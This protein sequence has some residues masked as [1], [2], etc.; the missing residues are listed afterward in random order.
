MMTVDEEVQEHSYFAQHKQCKKYLHSQH[1][2]P[3]LLAKLTNT[4][5]PAH[6]YKLKTKLIISINLISYSNPTTISFSDNFSIINRISH[7]NYK[8]VANF[9]LSVPSSSNRELLLVRTQSL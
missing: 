5:S 6:Y 8:L 3:L 2:V 9:L 7:V 4:S 1:A